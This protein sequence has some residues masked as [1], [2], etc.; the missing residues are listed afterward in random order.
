M[1]GFPVSDVCSSSTHQILGIRFFNGDVDEAVALMFERGGFIVA[2][3]GTCF[4]R[5]REDARYRRAVLAADLAIAD[6]GLMVLLWRL[7]RCESVQRLSGLKYLR[8]LLR[9]LK[10]RGSEKVFWVLPTERGRQKLFDWSRREA[11]SIETENCYVAPRYGVEV[12]DGNLLG[13]IEQRRPV[14]IVIA[15]GSGVQEKLGYYLRENLSY[16]PA[17]HCTGAA[18]GFI[19]GDQAAIPEWA[20]RFYLGWLFRSLAQPRIFIPRLSRA[21]EL[22]RLI[23]KYGEQLPPMASASDL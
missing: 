14:H 4:A 5:L 12:E 22:P 6:S 18:L 19:T 15:I 11:C 23:W 7:S 10:T 21:F 9:K 1:T 17:I 3:S 8:H 20:D 13:L 2:P 16:R